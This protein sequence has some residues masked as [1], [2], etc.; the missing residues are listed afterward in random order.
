MDAM[1]TVDVEARAEDNAE[2]VSLTQSPSTRRPLLPILPQY[3]PPAGAL[4]VD[5]EETRVGAHNEQRSPLYLA[6]LMTTS[7]EIYF[8]KHKDLLEVSKDVLANTE[9]QE[10]EERSK[11]QMLVS[12]ER[13]L[14]RIRKLEQLSVVSSNQQFSSV[15]DVPSSDGQ[16]RTSAPAASSTAETSSTAASADG[17]LKKMKQRVRLLPITDDDRTIFWE[18]IKGYERMRAYYH[19]TVLVGGASTPMG[20]NMEAAF[21]KMLL[22]ERH[23]LWVNAHES[24]LEEN[25]SRKVQEDENYERRVLEATSEFRAQQRLQKRIRDQLMCE[26]QNMQPIV[27]LGAFTQKMLRF[28]MLHWSRCRLEI[29]LAR[30]VRIWRQHRSIKRTN[31]RAAHLLIEWLQKSAAVKSMSFRVFRGLR[32]FV[33]RVKCVQGLWKKRQAIRKLKFLI[34]EKAW[35]D[36]ETVY[37]DTAIEEYENK[38]LEEEQ[39]GAPKKWPKTGSNPKS[40]KKREIWMRFVPESVRT[41]VIIEFL[42]KAEKEYTQKFRNQEDDFFPQLV[43]TL[44]GEHPN[45]ARTYI[46]AVAT[47]PSR[48]QSDENVRGVLEDKAKQESEEHKKQLALLLQRRQLLRQASP[49]TKGAPLLTSEPHQPP[50]LPS[51]GLKHVDDQRNARLPKQSFGLVA[52]SYNFKNLPMLSE[53]TKDVAMSLFDSLVDQHFNRFSRRGS[54]LLLNPSVI[55]FQ[56]TMKELKKICS[57]EPNSSFF[58]CLSTH[59]ARVTRGTNEGSYV[60][61]SETRLSSEE[62][63]VLTAIHERDL[64]QMI[65]DIPCKN[66]FVALELCQTQEPKDKIVDE[67]DTIRHR[68]HEQFFPKLHKQI[69]QLRLQML[70]DRGVRMPSNEELTEEAIRSNPKL[71]NLILMESCDVKS[72]V[73]VRANDERVSNFL[74]RFRDAFRGAAITPN[75]DKENDFDQGP[76]NSLFAKEVLEYVCRSIRDDATAHNALVRTE[77]KSQVRTR[78]EHAAEFQDITHTP[79]VLGAECAI[80]FGLGEIPEP[81]TM[82]PTPPA[83]VSSSL[84]S[85]TLR[86]NYTIPSFT[87]ELPTVL[88]YHIQRRGHGRACSDEASEASAWKRA[89]AFQVLSYEEVVRDGVVPPATVTVYGLSSDTAYCFRAR[90]RTAGGWGPFS[91]STS[92]YRTHSATSTLDQHETI[93]LAALREGAKGIAKIMEK[94]KNAGAIHRYAAE[95]LATMAMKGTLTVRGRHPGVQPLEP[96]DLPVVIAVRNAMLKFKKDMHLQQQGCILFGRLAGVSATWRAALLSVDQPSITSIVQAIVNRSDRDFNNDLTRCATWALEQLRV[97]AIGLRQKPRHVLSEHAAATRLQSMYRCRKAR[98]G[99]RELARSIY[100]QAIDPTSGMTYIFNTR[101]GATFW[102]LPQFAL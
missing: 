59:G 23:Q 16:T 89:A 96:S 1:A 51:N 38:R 49:E 29:H 62:E 85:I 46:K 2:R 42:Q 102:E 61:F 12:L 71:L 20:F 79:G 7:K 58:M 54:R 15:F 77:Y 63:L 91:A 97:G 86:W 100:A 52:V 36:L 94:H 70:L 99:V 40:R 31:S 35:N 5:R 60:L 81:P 28:L 4:V 80:D 95:I 17:Q 98:E 47:N 11:K 22:E 32:I 74:L 84:N 44:R 45:R 73:P 76:R 48:M 67:A 57:E 34:V 9:E 92:G 69:V 3:P 8:A 6:P 18:T 41:E 72:E 27:M 53:R 65:H 78:Y 26:A 21:K 13:H 19:Q 88:G 75:L 55:E 66:K 10:G 37:V 43:Q 24:R 90:A 68:I 50:I 82:S 33:R 93:R 30:T 56:D 87:S 64:A 39:H 83:F 14:A 101:T 25:K